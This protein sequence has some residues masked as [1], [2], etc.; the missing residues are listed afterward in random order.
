MKN[1]LLWG[2]VVLALLGVPEFALAA[3]LE[4]NF[5]QAVEKSKGY[6]GRGAALAAAGRSTGREV[7]GLKG[8]AEEIRALSLLLNERHRRR[9]E[10]GGGAL[11][12][13]RQ[14]EA[15]ERFQAGAQKLIE[16]LESL[17]DVQAL[18][19]D[20]WQRLEAVLEQLAPSRS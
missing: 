15:V 18:T 7:Q 13:Q 14:Q 2:G 19:P 20:R 9:G 4:R 3:S 12:R 6:A 16:T 10:K 1:I 17:S 11:A 8:Q 5:V